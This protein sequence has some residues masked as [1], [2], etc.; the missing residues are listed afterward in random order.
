MHA[1]AHDMHVRACTRT[2]TRYH[3]ATVNYRANGRRRPRCQE[4]GAQRP[5]ATLNYDCATAP[6]SSRTHET[7]RAPEAGGHAGESRETPEGPEGTKGIQETPGGPE[8]QGD[9]SGPQ[10]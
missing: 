4:K 5:R 9:R 8:D 7:P 10:G 2:C 6:W 3:A 1:R